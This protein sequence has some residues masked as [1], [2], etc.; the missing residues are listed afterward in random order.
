V[1]RGRVIMVDLAKHG[2]PSPYVCRVGK[3]ITPDTY[4]H[5][6]TYARGM[7]MAVHQWRGDGRDG[8]P[9][10]ISWVATT[11]GRLLSAYEITG[12]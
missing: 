8:K 3:D 4:V 5:E 11:S 2:D 1:G 7:G 9:M 6:L 10:V 12:R